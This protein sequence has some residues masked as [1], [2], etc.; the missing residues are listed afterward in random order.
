MY[1]EKI[2]LTPQEILEHEFK[3]NARGYSPQEVD[4]FLDIVMR[5]YVG[6][7]NIIHTLDTQ[8]KDLTN[9][10][11]SL[12]EEIRHIQEDL[13]N[14]IAESTNKEKNVTNIDLLKRVSQLEKIV[15]GKNE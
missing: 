4:K 14:A 15:Y 5:D 6:F 9:E 3:I 7:K 8:V 10:N 2:S 11:Y 12:K 1:N 13:E